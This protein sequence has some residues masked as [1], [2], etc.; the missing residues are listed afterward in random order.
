MRYAVGIILVL[1]SG[2]FII[3]GM[4]NYIARKQ[5]E[6]ARSESERRQSIEYETALKKITAKTC[7]GCDR[8]IIQREGVDTDFC[9]RCGIRL[10]RECEACGNRNISFHR[11]CL[12]CCAPNPEM[13]QARNSSPVFT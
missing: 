13:A 10:Q 3:S 8:S 2:H 1:I 4:R 12:S 6:E 5:V 7:P 11:F 9:V